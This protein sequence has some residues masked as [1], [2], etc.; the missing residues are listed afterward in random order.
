MAC[1]RDIFTFIFFTRELAAWPLF[2]LSTSR[3]LPLGRSSCWVSSV[4]FQIRVFQ[5]ECW[6]SVFW[7]IASIFKREVKVP[8]CHGILA[9]I[10][11]ANILVQWYVDF[12]TC[13][14]IKGTLLLVSSWEQQN[15]CILG[16]GQSLELQ[17]LVTIL[18]WTLLDIFKLT[19]R[20]RERIFSQI[21]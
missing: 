17:E 6:H 4:V 10:M 19:S 20:S 2:E 16:V 5:W 7:W 18:R 8:W 15:Y 9:S 11:A 13:D 21:K 3:A 14:L 1:N 12:W